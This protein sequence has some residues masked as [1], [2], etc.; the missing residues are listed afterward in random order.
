MTGV[1]GRGDPGEDRKNRFSP[2]IL[3]NQSS[4]GRKINHVLTG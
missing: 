4:F 2:K 1:F 3:N